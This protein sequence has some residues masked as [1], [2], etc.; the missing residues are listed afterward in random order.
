MV[1]LPPGRIP[2]FCSPCGPR[3]QRWRRPIHHLTP[4]H[5]HMGRPGVTSD[6]RGNRGTLDPMT[7]VPV[8]M[9]YPLP[10]STVEPHWR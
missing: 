8:K 10:L 6:P 4:A 5:G 7:V 9:A 2:P 3:L 1:A